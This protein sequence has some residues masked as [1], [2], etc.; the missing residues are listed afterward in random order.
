MHNTAIGNTPVRWDGRETIEIVPQI[1]NKKEIETVGAGKLE[2]DWNI[3]G[4]AV[5]KEVKADKLILIRAQNSGELA[6]KLTLRNGGTPVS[7]TT[8]LV[9]REPKHDAWI[10]RTPEVDE[11]PVDNQFYARDDKNEGTL[12]CSGKLKQ[13]TDILFLKLFADK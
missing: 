12:Y 4:L 10:E 6:V 13:K 3:A 8:T 5:I 9:V 1:S 11:K 2:Y 7:S